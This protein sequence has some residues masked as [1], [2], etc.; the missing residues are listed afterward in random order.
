MS[1]CFVK[2]RYRSICWVKVS[3]TVGLS[4]VLGQG[5]Y[6]SIYWVKVSYTVGLSSGSRS[7][8]GSF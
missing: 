1:I 6:R 2:V 7:V 3:Y 4:T 5:Q 8:S